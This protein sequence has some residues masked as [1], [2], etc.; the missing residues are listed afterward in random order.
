MVT[1][2]YFTPNLRTQFED[3]LIGRVACVVCCTGNVAVFAQCPKLEALSLSC[4]RV[5]GNLKSLMPCTELR[6][7]NLRGAGAVIGMNHAVL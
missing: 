2:V 7:L 3:N 1:F 5:A 6:T 4:T